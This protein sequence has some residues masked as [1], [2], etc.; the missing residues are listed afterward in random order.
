MPQLPDV[1]VLARAVEDVPTSSP[2]ALG[3]NRCAVGQFL[4]QVTE[5]YGTD[6]RAAVDALVAR[7]DGRQY[8]VGD[9]RDLLRRTFDVDAGLDSIRRHRARLDPTVAKGCRCPVPA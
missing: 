5:H 3:G 9:V 4:D 7:I 1:A 8:A 6:G 2:F